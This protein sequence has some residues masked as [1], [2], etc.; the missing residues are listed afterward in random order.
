VQILLS[1]ADSRVGAEEQ[2]GRASVEEGI[3]SWKLIEAHREFPPR[4]LAP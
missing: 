4:E 3:E 2:N 1:S